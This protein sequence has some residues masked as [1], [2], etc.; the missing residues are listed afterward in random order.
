MSSVSFLFVFK[1]R[2]ERDF[3]I[4]DLPDKD[5]R[6][7][8]TCFTSPKSRFTGLFATGILTTFFTNPF[9]IG[10]LSNFDSPRFWAA[11]DPKRKL[12]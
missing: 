3:E 5:V 2:Y 10:R 4:R 12:A 1:G 7:S 8:L 9:T 6:T 11:M